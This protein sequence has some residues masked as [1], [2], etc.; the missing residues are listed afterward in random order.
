M[1]QKINSESR[2]N[3]SR[4]AEEFGSCCSLHKGRMMDV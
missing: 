2:S 3:I 4:K 1:Q